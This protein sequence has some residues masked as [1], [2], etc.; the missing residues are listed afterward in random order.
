[1]SWIAYRDAE[2]AALTR[3][4]DLARVME[5]HAERALD[6]NAMVFRQLEGGLG[7]R[8]EFLDAIRERLPHIRSI[9][10]GNV[11]S[12]VADSAFV[13]SRGAIV[14]ALDPAYFAD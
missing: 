14:L 4:D 8:A 13:I 7:R 6:T 2:R 1:M 11:T 12:G 10:V 3:L 5:E 9:T